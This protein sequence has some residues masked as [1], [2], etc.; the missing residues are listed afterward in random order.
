MPRKYKAVGLAILCLAAMTI[1]AFAQSGKGPLLGAANA[2]LDYKSNKSS[3]S[4]ALNA[5]NGIATEN[6]SGGTN[7]VNNYNHAPHDPNGLYQGDDKIGT[8]T[9]DPK[10]DE[11]N[12]TIT[13]KAQHFQTP[14]DLLKYV[15]YGHYTLKCD[16]PEH[17]GKNAGTELLVGCTCQIIDKK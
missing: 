3:S 1:V 14:L 5:P 9:D 15:S 2:N 8:V 16:F 11:K 12:K 7:T 17:M 6:Q 13:F 4:T 10:I